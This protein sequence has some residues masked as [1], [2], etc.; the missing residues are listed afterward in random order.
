MLVLLVPALCVR[1]D[2]VAVVGAVA[3]VLVAV[4]VVVT[5]PGER[6]RTAGRL[7]MTPLPPPT[8]AAAAAAAAAVCLSL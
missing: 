4:T 3:T 7:R 1:C 6:G 2:V 8:P 5:R